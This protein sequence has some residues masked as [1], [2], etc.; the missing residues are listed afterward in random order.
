MLTANLDIDSKAI[1]EL[2]DLFFKEVLIVNRRYQRKLV[3][4]IDEK[5][6]LI[7]SIIEAYPIPLLLFVKVGENKEILDGMQR[8]EAIMSFIEQ[9]FDFEGNYF[10][11]DSTALTKGLKDSGKIMQKEPRLDRQTST[12]FARYKFAV[13]EYSSEEKDIDEV[14]RRINS[15]GRTL[16]KQELRSAGRV[17]NFSELVRK[18]ATIIRG[19]TSHSDVLNLN[20]MS[21]I[22]ISGENLDY[23]VSI[24]DHFYVTNGVLTRLSIRESDD[25]ELIANILGYIC[26]EKKPPSGATVLDEFYGVKDS[27]HSIEQMEKLEQFI[28]TYSEDKLMENMIFVYEQIKLLFESN[29]IHFKK[30]ILGDNSASKMCPRYYQAVFLAMYE[31]LINQNKIISDFQGLINKLKHI[32]DNI[33][34]VTD[35]GRWA[36]TSRQ[37]SVDDLAALIDRYFILSPIGRENS[38]WVTEINSV[39]VSSKTEQANYDFKQGLVTLNGKHTFNDESLRQIIATCVGINN[40]GKEAKGFVLIG[41]ADTPSCANRSK[42]LYQVDSIESN[43][44][45]ITGI[46]HEANVLYGNLDLYFSALK[47]KIE[48]FNFDIKLK[49]QILKDMR[50]CDYKGKHLIRIEVKSVGHP[51]TLDDEMYLRQGTTTDKMRSTLEIIALTT[52]YNQGR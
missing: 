45:Y 2:Y 48:A 41:V 21:Q 31:I 47:Q 16:S 30:H 22:S 5:R 44:F 17:T 34:K 24:S 42:E 49:Q 37:R 1:E 4:S 15:N 6:A 52:N 3:W 27:A 26:L 18:V 35:G 32:G 40:I 29:G 39:L 14:F 33:I 12:L 50:V 8:L 38:A 51:C 23:G 10:D 7:S 25:E 43:G 19:D 46:D 13:S 11:L 9:R 20:A 28:Q 36:A